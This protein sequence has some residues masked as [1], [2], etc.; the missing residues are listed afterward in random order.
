[1]YPNIGLTD[2]QRDGVRS[3]LTTILADEYLLYT[4]TR[5]CH[6]NVRGPQFV[7]L[8]SFFEEQYEAL[9]TIVDDIAERARALGYPAI[10]TLA[11]F[12]EKT[13]LRERPGHYPLARDML[14]D[15]LNDHEIVIRQLRLDL[16]TC[17]EPYQD[18]GTSDFLTGLLAQHEKMSWMLRASLQDGVTEASLTS[19]QWSGDDPLTPARVAS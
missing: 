13:R 3:I 9:N 1:M 15:L 2:T 18:A 12:L 17:M 7:Q 4:K 11:E 10:G 8:H 6:W 16:E 19:Q 5:N 14:T